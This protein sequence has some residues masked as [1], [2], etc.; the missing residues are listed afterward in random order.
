MKINVIDNT[1][2]L[3]F[4][5]LVRSWPDLPHWRPESMSQNEASG[6]INFHL[7]TKRNINRFL[8]IY[9]MIASGNFSSM[10]CRANKNLSNKYK[11]YR[12]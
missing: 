5:K 3:A 9:W 11:F 7:I 8:H 6:N 10:T 1:E 2:I 12:S 4:M